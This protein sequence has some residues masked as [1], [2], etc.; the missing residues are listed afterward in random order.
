MGLRKPWPRCLSTTINK[1]FLRQVTSK[2]S[3]RKMQSVQFLNQLLLTKRR[4]R[5]LIIIIMIKYLLCRGP[6]ICKL[7]M[8]YK[9][10]EVLRTI[11]QTT[12]MSN[13]ARQ[14]PSIKTRTNIQYSKE[15]SLKSNH[16]FVHWAKSCNQP[17]SYNN[18]Q[19]TIQTNFIMTSL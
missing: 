6:N 1:A 16:I 2:Q 11:P 3:R 13:T 8:R 18:G 4:G 9:V 17:I 5:R 14:Q 7:I 19:I 10:L 12:Q 15:P